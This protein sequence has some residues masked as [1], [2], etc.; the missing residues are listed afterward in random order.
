[1]KFIPEYRFNAFNEASADFLISIGIKGIVLDIDNTLEPY[2]NPVPSE[3]VLRWFSD[4]DTNGIKYSIVS[5]NNRQRVE[6][7]AKGL[8]IPYFYKSGKPFK[9]CVL[10]AMEKMGTN[11]TNTIFMG[12]QILTDVL[13]AHR[14]KIPAIL[15]PPIKDK[16]DAFT[17][18]KRWIEGIILKGYDKKEENK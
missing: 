6:D 18:F 8:N 11:K 13:A 7:F 4:L 2:E 9:R 17:R 3:P 10:R 12:D 5:N 16:Q 14:A 15:V 1:M